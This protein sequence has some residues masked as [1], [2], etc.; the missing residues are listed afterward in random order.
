M[1]NRV[2]ILVTTPVQHIKNVVKSLENI[3]DVTYLSDP[4]EKKVINKIRNFDV[5]F[6]NPNK[7]KFYLGKKILSRAIKLKVVCTAS[8]GTN[9]IDIDYANSKGI[10]IISITKE[11]KILK[12]ITSTAELALALTLSCLRNLL[13]ANKSVMRGE[14]DYT[15]FIGN[16]MNLL[17]VG[18]IG[19]GRLGSM[20]AKYCL[21]LGSSIFVYDPNKKIKNNKINQVKNINSLAKVADI[22]SIHVHVSKNTKEMI[23]SKL[24]NKMKKNVIIINTSRGEIVNEEDL[25]K[26]LICNP[27]AKI[28]TDVLYDEIR[29]RK[30]SKLYKLSK[31]T[32]Q[33]LITPHIGGMTNEAQELAYNHA[34]KLLKNYIINISV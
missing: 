20:Y 10:K 28:G 24:L 30:K 12:K 31:K 2:K 21:A 32:N 19:Y 33:V 18:I 6:T 17:N 11:I 3:G 34:V 9:H 15:K 5:I 22:I 8:T 14:W 23:N 26:F 4:D 1:K 16:Q 13:P 25:V 29:N 27:L 7:S